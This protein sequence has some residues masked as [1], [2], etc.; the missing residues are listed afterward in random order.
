LLFAV[1]LVAIV[2]VH[3]IRSPRPGPPGPATD[4]AVLDLFPGA[5]TVVRDG[6]IALT[7][8]AAGLV[9]GAAF[10]TARLPPAVHGYNGEIDALVGLTPDGRIAQVRVRSHAETPYYFAMLGGE[11]TAAFA[12]R[13]PDEVAGLDAISGATVSSEALRDDVVL[14]AAR[15]AMTAWNFPIPAKVAALGGTRIDPAPLGAAAFV[16]ALALAAHLG[17]TRARWLR[18]PARVAAFAV[19]GVWLN[20][21]VSIGTLL[22]LVDLAPPRVPALATVLVFALATAPLLGRVYCNHVCPFGVIQEVAYRLP[23]RKW[24]GSGPVARV[25]ADTRFVLV[26]AIAVLVLLGGRKAFGAFEPYAM[27]FRPAG[28]GTWLYAGAAVAASASVKRFWCRFLCPTGACLDALGAWRRA[29][30]DLAW[31]TGDEGR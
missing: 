25:L 30:T 14:G 28:A 10:Q 20:V 12:G 29:K 8:D 31:E 6:E 2:A 24:K 27:L 21:P 16:L 23:T 18:V 17:T 7:K 3:A 1:A 15:A 9:V 13:T 4:A 19:V 22:G 11:F 26:I 5:T